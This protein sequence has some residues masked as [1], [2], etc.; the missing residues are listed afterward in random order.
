MAYDTNSL[1]DPGGVE[2]QGERPSYITKLDGHMEVFTE[3][4]G[5]DRFGAM[6]MDYLYTMEKDERNGKVMRLIDKY[7]Y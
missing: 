1:F 2:N 5:H 7:N 6:W 3:T 4:Y